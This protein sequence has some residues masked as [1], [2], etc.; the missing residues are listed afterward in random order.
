M[1]DVLAGVLTQ[2]VN[3]DHRHNVACDMYHNYV[4]HPRSAAVTRQ[5]SR[6]LLFSCSRSLDTAAEQRQQL[7]RAEEQRKGLLHAQ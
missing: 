3:S 2:Q 7:V 4:K 1:S 5:P 6:L